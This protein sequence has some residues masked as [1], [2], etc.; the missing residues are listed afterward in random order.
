VDVAV[1]HQVRDFLSQRTPAF[2]F[3]GEEEGGSGPDGIPM[4]AL[5]PVDGTANFVRGMPLCAVSL[6]LIHDDQPVIG[7][8]GLP[9]LAARYWAEE[10]HGAYRDGLQIHA[11][12]TSD[13]NEAIVAFGDFALGDGALRSNLLRLEV[14]DR[15]AAGA[16]RVRMVGLGSHRSCLAGRGPV[17]HEH[18]AP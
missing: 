2:A 13:L 15:L 10:G 8:I 17:R 14:L 12:D 5:D 9:F 18:H 3:L 7:V 4:W 1:E 6:A 16:L 11:R